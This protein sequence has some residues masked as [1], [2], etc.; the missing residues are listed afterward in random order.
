MIQPYYYIY[1]YNIWHIYSVI[2]DHPSRMTTH[3]QH[4]YIYIYDYNP[5]STRMNISTRSLEDGQCPSN[6]PCRQ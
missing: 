1:I 2:R 3:S 6:T 4:M 5:K